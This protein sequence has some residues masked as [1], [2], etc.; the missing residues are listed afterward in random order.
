MDSRA[1][2]RSPHSSAEQVSRA[3][4]SAKVEVSCLRTRRQWVQAKRRRRTNSCVGCHP[5]GA[6]A[7]L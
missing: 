6:W 2:A 5:T 3:L 4:G 7:R 1:R